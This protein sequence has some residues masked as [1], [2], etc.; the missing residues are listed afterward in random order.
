MGRWVGALDSRVSHG[1]FIQAVEA[2]GGG[3]T[4]P[5]VRER[6]LIWWSAG[7][8]GREEPAALRTERSRWL[9]Q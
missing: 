9:R 6:E 3:L 8:V 5:A 1:H 4:S 7:S 2:T